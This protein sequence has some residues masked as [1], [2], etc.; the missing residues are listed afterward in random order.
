MSIFL[1]PVGLILFLFLILGLERWLAPKL[2]CD[3][4]AMTGGSY[5]HPI[6]FIGSYPLREPRDDRAHMH[7]MEVYWRTD[8]PHLHR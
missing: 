5:G 4:V 8:S 6:E 7:S 3:S 2:D 1:I